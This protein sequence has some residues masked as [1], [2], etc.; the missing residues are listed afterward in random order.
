MNMKNESI[1]SF[2]ENVVSEFNDR[3]SSM[4][5][6]VSAVLAL[7]L[8]LVLYLGGQGAF[9]GR[10]DA[11][12][13]ALFL[14]LAIP[15]AIFFAAYF[16]WSAFQSFILAADLRFI[17]A[18]QAWR[19]AGQHFL[20]LYAAGVL[21]ALFAFPAGLGDMAIGV[22]APWI[23]LGLVRQPSFATSRQYVM[24]NVL[25]IVDF[26]VA[27]SMGVLCSGLFH[28]INGLIGNLTTSPM[29]RLPLV[30]VPTFV[31]PFFTML[32]LTALFQAR[33]LAR[34]GKTRPAPVKVNQASD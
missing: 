3:H 34:S 12:P 18:I 21:P 32:H 11:P 23:L 24:W 29:S 10:P 22:T 8:G 28:G 2:T 7:W 14:G 19:W 1:G 15:L 25:G 26:V 4:K 31:V 33:Q 13:V 30:L 5:L 16:G 20:F 27:V 6:T 17:T 9:V